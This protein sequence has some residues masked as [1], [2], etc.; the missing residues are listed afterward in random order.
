MIPLQAVVL[1]LCAL[2]GLAVVTSRDPLRQTIVA[3]LY[4]L[5]LIVLFVV[6]QAPD[7]ALSELVVGAVGYP[8][9]I[10][11]A[12]AKVSGRR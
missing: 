12:L 2:G 8:L 1:L 3:G 5:T 10:L 4:G 9:V 11:A 7:V 6:F